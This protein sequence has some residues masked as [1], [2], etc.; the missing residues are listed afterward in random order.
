METRDRVTERLLALS[1][2]MLAAAHGQQWEALAAAQHAR[3]AL[4]RAAFAG[5]VAEQ[6]AEPVAAC[7]LE[8]QRLDRELLA[9]IEAG[10]EDIARQLRE[11]RGG[12]EGAETY[13]R[14]SGR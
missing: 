1:Q 8:L 4:L 5:P 3:D 7:I 9:L 14:F 12:R 13:R 11:L 10:R 6:E 2:D